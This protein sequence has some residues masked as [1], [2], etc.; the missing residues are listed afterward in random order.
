MHLRNRL[1]TYT[2]ICLQVESDCPLLLAS[3][4]EVYDTVV[5][6]ANAFPLLQNKIRSAAA[7]IGSHCCSSLFSCREGLGF[8]TRFHDNIQKLKKKADDVC[9]VRKKERQALER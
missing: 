4:K 1:H 7:V 6:S 3:Q 2:Y 5:T 8:Y 9:V